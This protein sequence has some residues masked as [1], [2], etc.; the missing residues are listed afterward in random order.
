MA[1]LRGWGLK[2]KRL[3]GE[4]PCGHWKTMTFI[5]ALRSQT[6]EAPCVFDGP[7]NKKTFLAYVQSFLLPTLKPGDVVVLDNL[8]SH[9]CPEVR[10]IMREKKVKML[11]LPAYSPD[12]NPIENVFSKLK[13]FIRKVQAR[14]KEALVDAIGEILD[15]FHPQECAQIIKN[16][17]YT[18][19]VKK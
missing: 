10:K 7:I 18:K 17:G 13:H 14:T 8:G 15:L 11:F 5:A 9:K 1:P 16:A 6:I 2:G 19:N 3:P 4:A 12:L